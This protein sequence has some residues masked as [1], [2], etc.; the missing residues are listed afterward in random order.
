MDKLKII[1]H[2]DLL[3][4][5]INEIPENLPKKDNTVLLEGE[6][7]NHFHRLG[8]GTVYEVEPTLENNFTLGYFEIQVETPL[9]HEEHETIILNPGKYKFMS[10]REYDP[11]A[12]RRVLD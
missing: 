9:T 2:G 12:N 8:G 5:Q 10:Q 11:Q 1:R 3:L 4:L 7:S 6:A